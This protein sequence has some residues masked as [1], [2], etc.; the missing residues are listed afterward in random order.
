MDTSTH[1][2][3]I[4]KEKLDISIAPQQENIHSRKESLFRFRGST[5]S[6]KKIP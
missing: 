1:S 3:G 5:K 2:R 6:S 4:E